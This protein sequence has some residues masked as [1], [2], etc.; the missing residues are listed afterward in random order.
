MYR[1]R[2][3]MYLNAPGQQIAPS[4]FWKIVAATFKE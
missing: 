4:I 3:V 1:T 2:S